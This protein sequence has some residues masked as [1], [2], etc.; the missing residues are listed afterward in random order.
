M[1]A[2]LSVKEIFAISAALIALLVIHLK[3]SA[4]ISSKLPPGPR[5]LPIFGNL[6]Q[7]PVLRPYPQV[8]LFYYVRAWL[9]AWTF[10]VSP[11]G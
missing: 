6:F 10:T 9:I 5:K 11:L 3:R 8:R 7:V 4:L 2:P 1:A